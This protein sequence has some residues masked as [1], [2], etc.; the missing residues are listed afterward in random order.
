[1]VDEHKAK[2]RRMSLCVKPTYVNNNKDIDYESSDATYTDGGFS[3]S[4]DKR[5]DP[6]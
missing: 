5:K 6:E 1:M 2:V 4:K 3:E